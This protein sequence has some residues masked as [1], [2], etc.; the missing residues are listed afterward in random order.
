MHCGWWLRV[1]VGVKQEKGYDVELAQQT[2]EALRIRHQE[3]S[4][5]D[6]ISPS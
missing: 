4:C 5:D 1:A 6:W 2:P 3:Q